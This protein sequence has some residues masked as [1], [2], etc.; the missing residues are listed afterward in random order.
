MGWQDAPL[1]D[2]KGGWQSAPIVGED[3]EKP[4][5]GKM[6]KREVMNSVPVTALTGLIRGAGSIGATVGLPFEG[7]DANMQ[8][9]KAMDSAFAS[10][11]VDTDSLGYGAGKLGGEIAGTA[12]AGPAI[13]SVS[14]MAQWA[15]R[16]AQ[17]VGSAG[18]KTGAVPVNLLERIGDFGIRT[19]GG[20]VAGGASAGMVDP[21]QAAMGAG[22]GAATP[23]VLMLAGKVGGAVYNAVKTGKPGAGRMLAEA[24]GVSEQEVQ[25][26]AKALEAAPDSI[27]PGS[28]LTASQALQKQG[29][30]HPA[31]KLLER[32]V[33][34]GPGG[35][36]LLRRYEQQGAA[37]MDALRGQGAQTYQ[38]AAAQESD[39]IGNRLGAVLRTQAEDDKALA[40]A[41]WQE[42]D[43]RA[44]DERVALRLPL[45]DMDA[46]LEKVLGPGTAGS[47]KSAKGLMRE[48]REIGTEKL[49]AIKL[50][51]KSAGQ[52]QSL[53]QAVRSAGGIKPGEYLAGEIAALGR[54][55][56]G[57]TGLVAKTGRD[58]EMMAN[59]M[60]ERGFIPDNDPATLLEMLRGGGGRGVLADDVM[61]T[62]FQRR[63]EQSMGDAPGEEIIEK[64]VP[65]DQFQRLRRSAGELHAKAGAKPGKESEAKVLNDIRGLLEKKVDDAAGGAL[66]ADEVMP[67]G[68]REAYNR[69]RGMTKENA[70]RYKQG[71]NIQSILRKPVGKNYELS[72]DEI[73]RKLWHGGTGLADDVSRFKSVL[74]DAN[75]TPAMDALRRYIMTDA[76]SKTTAAG[77]LG[78]ALPRYVETRMP[79]LLAALSD[80]Q[81]KAV[82]GVAGDIRNA[83]AAAAVPGLLGSDTHAKMARSLDAGILGSPQAKVIGNILSVKGIG[84]GTARNW[85]ADT[86]IRH[87]GKTIAEL[88]A[89]PKAA[90]AALKDSG[91]VQKAEPEMLKALRDVAY[92]S[93]PLLATD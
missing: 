58:V 64:A 67:P 82:T 15:P 56:S 11:G 74:N 70:G 72:G 4:S 46:A 43:K 32:H 45:S 17:A 3:A 63:L 33:A 85:L 90:A 41:A 23:G 53:E 18:M 27:L 2:A 49:D 39:A 21:Q 66:Q 31:M 61:E 60:H 77:N 44:A 38:G 75:Q 24:L 20:A 47:G 65:F 5:F 37:R 22:I 34:S 52:T 50:T 93:A 1:V 88:L 76:A 86:V 84:V 36:S 42:L 35:D 7:W 9:R 13:A 8:R 68:F 10:M 83:E 6:L 14:K 73:M 19:A 71:D 57:T 80:D 40:R 89:N 62:T 79:G 91:F 29:A 26:M 30:N 59:M 81:L 25:A 28:K 55:Q 12:G 78:A 48:A 92:R 51:P 54:K 16:L 69:A 87:K